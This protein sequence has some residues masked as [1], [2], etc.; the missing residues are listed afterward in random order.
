M[1]ISLNV[2]PSRFKK[3]HPDISQYI[4]NFS[5]VTFHNKPVY[6]TTLF[7]CR[8]SPQFA[9]RGEML[10]LAHEV[11]GLEVMHTGAHNLKS[12]EM[13]KAAEK[14]KNLNFAPNRASD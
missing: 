8:V 14:L 2:Q 1:Q 5:F 10:V 7:S 13:K 9:L 11:G 12:A 4:A 6:S 3:V